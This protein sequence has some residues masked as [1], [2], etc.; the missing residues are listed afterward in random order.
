MREDYMWR[1]LIYIHCYIGCFCT[2]VNTA[3]CM[4]LVYH[5]KLITYKHTQ[6]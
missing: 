3:I 6:K 5:V 1:F 4:H 2:P